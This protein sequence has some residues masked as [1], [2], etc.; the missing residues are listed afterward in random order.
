MSQNLSTFQSVPFIGVPYGQPVGLCLPRQNNV[1]PRAVRIDIDWSLYGASSTNQKIG[2]SVNLI[3]QGSTSPALD[4]I[5]SVYI[6]NTFSEVPIYVQFPD[7]LFTVV[8]PPGSVVMS[9]VATGLQ[10][11]TIY[12][13]GFT[14]GNIPKTSV[15]FMNIEKDGYFIPTAFETPARIIFTGAV[16]D[17]GSKGVYNFGPVPIGTAIND[18]LVVVAV[19]YNSAVSSGAFISGVTINGFAANVDATLGNGRRSGGIYSFPVST[20]DTA[21]LIVNMSNSNAYF[22]SAQIFSIYNL[23]S[24]VPIMGGAFGGNPNA[25]GNFTFTEGSVGVFGGISEVAAVGQQVNWIGADRQVQQFY[26]DAVNSTTSAAMFSSFDNELRTVTLD[27]NGSG[28]GLVG[29]T[30]R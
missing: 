30:Y 18:R 22:C 26:D 5:R 11:A 14:N 13:E 19:E 16:S 27:G 20:G 8:A 7:T 12:G 1:P 23:K 3:A 2:V 10:Q 15:H 29:A 28:A 17:T 4:Y 9:P 21:T 24:I 6:D 25:S